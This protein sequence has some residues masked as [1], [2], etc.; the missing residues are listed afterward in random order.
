MMAGGRWRG[1]AR[2]DGAPLPV[3]WGGRC[4]GAAEGDGRRGDATCMTCG[5]GLPYC[6]YGYGAGEAP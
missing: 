3:G 4:G 1:E 2:V 5:D 6:T